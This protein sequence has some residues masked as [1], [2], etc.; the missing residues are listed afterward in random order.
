MMYANRWTIY[1]KV[2]EVMYANSRAKSIVMCWKQCLP[3]VAQY[4]VKCGSNLC[5]PLHNI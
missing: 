1:R 3:T 4:I 5:Q 2:L